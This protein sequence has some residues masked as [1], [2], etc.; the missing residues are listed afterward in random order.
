MSKLKFNKM[1]KSLLF[2]ISF[3]VLGAC[4]KDSAILDTS[5]G[6]T[7]VP[8]STLTV[9]AVVAGANTEDSEHSCDP[10]GI[11]DTNIGLFYE[12]DGITSETNVESADYKA[13]TGT[14]T[15]YFA[16]L[17][18]G[19]YSIVVQNYMGKAVLTQ[20]ME[21]GKNEVLFEF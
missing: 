11:A 1:K 18:P 10:K 13:N 16:R 6:I 3:L 15:A 2:L 9:S 20:M 7:D 14:G 21:V 4:S 12:M 17:K 5:I 8:M 19:K